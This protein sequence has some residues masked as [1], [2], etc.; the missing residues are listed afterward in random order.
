MIRLTFEGNAQEIE[1]DLFRLVDILSNGYQLKQAKANAAVARQPGVSGSTGTQQ[2]AES[3]VQLPA[4]CEPAEPE[5]VEPEPAKKRGRPKKEAAPVV[6]EPAVEVKPEPVQV[7]AFPKNVDELRVRFNHLAS[8]KGVP[9]C[10]GIIKKYARKI[11]EIPVEK[12]AD[13]EADIV[14]A[15]A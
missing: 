12:Y 9:S 7:P 15:M 2:P 6:E 3:E 10:E 5:V 1:S 14:A 8:K 13:V 4:D 11:S